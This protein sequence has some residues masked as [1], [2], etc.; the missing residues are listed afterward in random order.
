LRRLDRS[1]L[2]DISLI[3]YIQLSEG[4]LQTKYLILLELGIFPTSVSIQPMFAKYKTWPT[5]EV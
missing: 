4:V 1:R 2:I 5:S 3:V